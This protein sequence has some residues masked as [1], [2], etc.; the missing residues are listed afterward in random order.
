MGL[1]G[2]GDPGC[3]DG[4]LQK[5]A[6]DLAGAEQ[7]HLDANLTY[8]AGARGGALKPL[9]DMTPGHCYAHIMDLVMRLVGSV[10]VPVTYALIPMFLSNDTEDNLPRHELSVVGML[11]PHV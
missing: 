11:L 1:L 10:L 6:Y 2:G 4:L 3:A 7:T 5:R 9:A 8:K